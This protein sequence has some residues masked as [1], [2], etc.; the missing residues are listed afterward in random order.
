MAKIKITRSTAATGNIGYEERRRRRGRNDW[1]L[2]ILTNNSLFLTITKSAM[3][4]TYNYTTRQHLRILVLWISDRYPPF[5]YGV[6]TLSE[7]YLGGKHRFPPFPAPFFPS[8]YFRTHSHPHLPSSFLSPKEREREGDGTGLATRRGQTEEK[9]GEERG[10]N[11]GTFS[12]LSNFS[13]SVCTCCDPKV[14]NRSNKAS[15]Q[16]PSPLF[17][18]LFLDK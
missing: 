4:G 17:F 10:D 2:D 1:V 8:F 18:L 15:L 5:F 9:R 12:V 11:R 6:E 14:N 7:W 13:T 3:C 16:P